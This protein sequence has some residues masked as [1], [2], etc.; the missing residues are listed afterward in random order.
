MNNKENWEKLFQTAD[1]AYQRGVS[2]AEIENLLLE[3]VNDEALVYAVVKKI[4]AEHQ[5][6]RAKSGKLFIGIACLLILAGFLVSCM[7]FYTNQSFV[8]A[9]Y[10]LT[11]VGIA[12]LLWGLFKIIG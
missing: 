9:M 8:W 11:T 1:E 2:Y 10:G 12:L 3:Q 4:K 7:N 6:E 5:K